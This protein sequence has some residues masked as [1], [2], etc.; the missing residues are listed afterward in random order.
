MNISE[1]IK[2]LHELHLA[3][4]LSDA[5]FAQAKAKLLSN[6]NLDKPD[7]TSGA[8]A[9]AAAGPANDLVQEFNRL[10]RSRND[11]WLGGVCGGLGRAS[12]MEAWIWRLAFVL[13]TLTFGFGVVIYLLL[14]IFVPDEEIGITKHEY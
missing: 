1:E 10:R 2:R 5:E 11:R 8:G 13:F 9:D 12:G 7:S 6:I 4:A 3:G 14:W